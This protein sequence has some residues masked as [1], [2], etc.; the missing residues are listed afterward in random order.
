[1][2]CCFIPVA[3]PLVIIHHFHIICVSIFLPKAYAPLHVNGNSELSIP[4]S[5]Q[6]FQPVAWRD[7]ER[8][9]LTCCMQNTQHA[10][11]ISLHSIQRREIA[12][13]KKLFRL[14]ILKLIIIWTA[15]SWMPLANSLN[16]FNS[17]R[18]ANTLSVFVKHKSARLGLLSI[19]AR[20]GKTVF[21]P[22][23][24]FTGRCSIHARCWF[25]TST[26]YSFSFGELRPR[27]RSAG[28][29][30]TWKR[31]FTSPH[32]LFAIISYFSYY[33]KK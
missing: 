25:K 29:V 4:I 12:R 23:S 19:L 2:L 10:Q 33:T 26:G 30:L 18:S 13:G 7:S 24:P 1:M 21:T 20:R 22:S 16:I 31:E 28:L 11:S 6:L 14:F 27:S 3:L 15:P 17:V 9:E 5:L 8:I 32:K